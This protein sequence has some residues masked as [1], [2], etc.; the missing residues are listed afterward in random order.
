MRAF[1]EKRR[2]DD[3][4]RQILPLHSVQGQD[5]NFHI[6]KRASGVRPFAIRDC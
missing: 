1:S 2:G 6:N 3:K 4:C 5:D